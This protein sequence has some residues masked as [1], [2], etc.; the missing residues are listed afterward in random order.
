MIPLKTAIVY[1]DHFAPLDVFGPLQAMNLCFGLLADGT[2]N[3]ACPLFEHYSVGNEVGTVK[4]GLNNYGP[5]VVCA[6]DFDTLPAVD[7]ILIPGG[8]GSRI[9]IDNIDFLGQLKALVKKT[10]LVLSI[11]TGAAL[12]ARTG[13]LDGKKATSNKTETSWKWVVGQSNEV[14]WEYPPRWVGEIDRKAKSGYMTSAGVAAGMDMM[15]ALISTLFGSQIVQNT[16]DRMEYTWNSDA[17]Q[18]PFSKLCP[19]S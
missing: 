11:C 4:V 14:L 2:P 10:P 19:T 15:L 12:L 17:A 16:Q 3:M 7:I 13:F 18:D 9:I 8:M 6:Y 5:D 1:Y